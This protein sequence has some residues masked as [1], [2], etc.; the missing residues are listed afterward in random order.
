[1]GTHSL[2]LKDSVVK[3]LSGDE[4]EQ[5]GVGNQGMVIDFTC[6]ET[7]EYI[8]M[9]ISLAYK[10]TRRLSIERREARMGGSSLVYLCPDGKS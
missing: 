4:L 10:L 9:L 1:M 7:L 2:E 5:I 8:P 3:H 6:N